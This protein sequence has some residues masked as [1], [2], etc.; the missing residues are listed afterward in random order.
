V[1]VFLHGFGGN[2]HVFLWPM[3]RLADALG[4]VL[5]APTYGCGQWQRHEAAG[6]VRATLDYLRTDDRADVDRTFLVGL[7]N[8]AM[9]VTRALLE[10]PVGFVGVAYV[11]P[12]LEA[13]KM[14]DVAARL[15]PDVPI[16]VVVGSEDDRTPAEYRGCPSA[17]RDGA[18]RQR[19]RPL[20]DPQRSRCRPRPGHRRVPTSRTSVTIEL[21]PML[22][23]LTITP[24]VISLLATILLLVRFLRRRDSRARPVYL[25]SIATFLVGLAGTCGTF[26]FVTTPQV[27]DAEPDRKANLLESRLA[28]DAF[29]LRL[30]AT[31]GLVVSSIAAF[32]V[33]WRSSA[34]STK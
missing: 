25:A 10:A 3:K 15:P 13:S 7:S 29:P 27:A 8:G 26:A 12:V 4:A 21:D 34:K 28:D 14:P 6:A 31:G 11:S 2:L 22:Y 17:T 9:G 16:V 24:V 23:V 20:F 1:I 5:V 33:G 30:G 18:G 32:V 19:R